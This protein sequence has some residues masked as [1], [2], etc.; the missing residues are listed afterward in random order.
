MLAG[1]LDVMEECYGD[2]TFSDSNILRACSELAQ[3]LVPDSMDAFEYYIRLY[4]SGPSSFYDPLRLAARVLERV[5]LR[6]TRR[7][8]SM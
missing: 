3:R 4:D 8:S 1:Y 7:T 2:E 5:I 6:A